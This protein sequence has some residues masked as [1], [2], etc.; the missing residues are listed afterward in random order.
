MLVRANVD[1]DPRGGRRARATLQDFLAREHDLDRP[2]ALLG[3]TGS[4]GLAVDEDLAA[5][6]SANFERNNLELRQRLPEHASVV[7]KAGLRDLAEA[8]RIVM[9]VVSEPRGRKALS[10]RLAD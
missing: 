2:A 7:E 5:E 8:Q 1:V 3:Q 4:Y 10:L 9:Q 6:R